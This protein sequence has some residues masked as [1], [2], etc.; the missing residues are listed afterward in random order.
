M[1]EINLNYRNNI[2]DFEK[3]I[4]GS[5]DVV[6]PNFFP[7]KHTFT[8]GMYLREVF[9]PKGSF[10]TSKIHKS[11]HPAFLMSGQI[12]IVSSEGSE[13]M[14]APCYIIS[15]AGTK[16]AGYAVTD[17]VWVTVHLNPSNTTDL[18]ILEKEVIAENYESYDKFLENKSSLIV[19]LKYKLIKF[20]SK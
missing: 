8:N 18:S 12:D 4:H 3:S 6:D 16:R 2:L 1:G 5:T 14:V 17:I 15:K 13:K 9:V 20:L 10:I 11:E 7:V 19:K